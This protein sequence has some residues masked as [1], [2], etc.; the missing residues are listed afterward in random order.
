MRNP[1]LALIS[2]STPILPPFPLFFSHGHLSLPGS[3]GLKPPHRPHFAPHTSTTFLLVILATIGVT[4]RASC[5]NGCV[6]VI[7]TGYNN[8]SK[9]TSFLFKFTWKAPITYKTSVSLL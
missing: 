1:L 6:N 2:S 4:T 3:Y 9:H 8:C 7:G 5:E